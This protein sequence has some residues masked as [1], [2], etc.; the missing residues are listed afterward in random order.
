MKYSG[1][2]QYL[3]QYEIGCQEK[4]L[5]CWRL[6][7]EIDHGFWLLQ[8]IELQEN[9]REFV[10]GEKTDAWMQGAKF[11]NKIQI[12]KERTLDHRPEINKGCLK[13]DIIVTLVDL[14]VAT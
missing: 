8:E 3:N 1:R 13:T 2:C 6:I 4:Q 7:L 10:L 11:S 14:F 9:Y 5:S 12:L